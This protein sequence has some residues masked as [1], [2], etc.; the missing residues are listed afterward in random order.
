MKFLTLTDD[1]S[2]DFFDITKDINN[3][4][5]IITWYLQLDTS[6]IRKAGIHKMQIGPFKSDA[7][8][9]LVTVKSNIISTNLYNPL[10]QISY[11][12]VKKNELYLPTNI[13]VVGRVNIYL[14][15]KTRLD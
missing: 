10:R 3:N 11:F 8:D 6:N 7:K 13:N 5:T 14:G 15:H 2:K 4:D 1:I 9:R 12:V